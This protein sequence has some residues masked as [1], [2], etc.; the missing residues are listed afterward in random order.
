MP[1][2]E[3]LLSSLSQIGNFTAIFGSKILKLVVAALSRRTIAT[4]FK[5]QLKVSKAVIFTNF[6]IKMANFDIAPD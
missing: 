4:V 1:I 2:Y 3:I 6:A 5:K